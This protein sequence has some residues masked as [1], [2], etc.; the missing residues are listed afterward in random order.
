MNGTVIELYKGTLESFTNDTR[1]SLAYWDSLTGDF[2]FWNNTAIPDGSLSAMM[3]FI[4]LAGNSIAKTVTVTVD[5]TKPSV[6]I[7]SPT[8]GAEICGNATIQFSASDEHLLSVLLYIDNTILNVTGQTSYLWDTTQVGD[9]AHT[10]KLLAYDK[11]GN[12]AETSAILVTTI[13]VRLGQEFTRNM[14]L[15]V[16]T[17]L[18]FVIGAIV[19]YAI[20]KRRPAPTSARTKRRSSS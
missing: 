10:I 18:G 8:S 13:N 1:L 7:T 5:N 6:S 17:P 19:V 4:D 16:G 2:A 11:A 14:Y 9:G 15:A 3:S 12:S 20:I